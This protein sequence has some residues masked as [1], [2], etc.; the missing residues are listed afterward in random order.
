[1][2]G[3]LEIP[4]SHK[5]TVPGDVDFYYGG[6]GVAW[7]SLAAAKDAVTGV[8]AAARPGKTIGVFI[9][10]KVVEYWWPDPAH[11]LD[12]DLVVKTADVSAKADITYVDAAISSEVT[13]RQ[14]ADTTLQGNI[15]TNTSAIAAE[16]TARTNAD[17]T[18]Q[19]NINTN[20]SAIAAEVTARTN[21]DIAEA[22]A[23]SNGDAATLTSAKSYA[24]GLLVSVYKDCG[25][26]DA[27]TGS[28]PATGGTGTSGAIKAGNA[29]EVSVAGTVAGENFDV[30][31][32]I[33]ALVDTPG[34]T[35]TNWARSE[36]NTQQATETL[37]GT[38]KIATN[39]TAIAGTNDTDFL[40]AL[41]ALALYQ[42]QRKNFKRSASVSRGTAYLNEILFYIDNAASI[43][44]IATSGLT[45]I[46]V[47]TS[48]AGTYAAP[49]YPI[50]VS[51]ASVFYIQ[52]D[53][54]NT[55]YLN[56]SITII[57]R[58]N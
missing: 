56:G 3:E 53:Y 32:L 47:K 37:R 35:L 7:P 10:G 58:D 1:M 21:A 29:F 16:V 40:T 5:R 26:W 28:F 11:I 30:G 31:D 39:S 4:G 20:T 41:K 24:D 15:N 23:R 17:T 13:S 36:H 9:S 19:G 43:T 14:N 18:L 8:V 55:S 49:S 57:G 51:S 52:F 2:A 22:T 33:R 46:L 50:A 42:D 54:S 34:Q 45:N 38:A 12:T 25:N 27:S 6:G 48:L 44:S